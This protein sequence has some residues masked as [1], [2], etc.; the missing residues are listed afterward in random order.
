MVLGPC[1]IG[2]KFAALLIQLALTFFR[3]WQV[4]CHRSPENASAW[5]VA[6]PILP[7][8]AL[9]IQELWMVDTIS[10]QLLSLLQSCCQFGPARR[11]SVRRCISLLENEINAEV[12]FH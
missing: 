1:L 11:P 9:P 12:C 10:S 6:P 3:W 7:G 8:S 5:D 4:L 2:C